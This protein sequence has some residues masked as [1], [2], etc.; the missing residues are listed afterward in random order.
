MEEAHVLPFH[1]LQGSQNTFWAICQRQH[2]SVP[3]FGLAIFL[4]GLSPTELLL[5]GQV[6]EL[7]DIILYD[8]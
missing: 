8:N 1:Q 2:V 6:G 5:H 3:T 4:Q 7:Q